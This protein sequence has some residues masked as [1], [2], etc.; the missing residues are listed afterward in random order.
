[1]HSSQDNNIGKE[2]SSRK[3]KSRDLRFSNQD[4]NLRFGNHNTLSLKENLKEGRGNIESRMAKSLSHDE[5]AK[6]PV[7]HKMN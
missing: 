5:K 3:D 6:Q 2:F 4:N 7:R 1:M